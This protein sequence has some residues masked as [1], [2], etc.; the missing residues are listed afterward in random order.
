MPIQLAWIDRVCQLQSGTDFTPR[1]ICRVVV[2]FEL[3]NGDRKW[4][5]ACFINKSLHQNMAW[6]K[7]F[8]E[9]YSE[10]LICRPIL[11]GFEHENVGLNPVPCAVQMRVEPHALQRGLL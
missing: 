8:L 2:N 7:V 9:D 11:A 5:R 10:F 3:F 6:K 1:W 4:R